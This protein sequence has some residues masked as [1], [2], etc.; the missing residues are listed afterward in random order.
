[1]LHSSGALITSV[2]HVIQQAEAAAQNI[3]CSVY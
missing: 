2:L 3:C 1:M